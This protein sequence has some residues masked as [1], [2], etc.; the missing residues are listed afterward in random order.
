[1]TVAASEPTTIRKRQVFAWSLWDWGAAAYNAVIVSFVFSPYVVRGV[2]GDEKPGGLSGNTWLGISSATAGLLIALIA[3]VTGQ[4]SDASGHRKRNLAIWTGLTVAVMLGLF[5][6]RNEPAYLWIALVLLAAGA[7][8]NEFAGVSYNAM[9][10][11][12]STPATIGR[13]SGF[14]WSMGYFGGIF[15]LLTCYVGFI[16]PEVGW[17]GATADGGLKYRMVAVFSAAWFAL[18][19]LPV[20]I[21]VPEK[22]PGPKQRRVGFF[23]SYKVLARDIRELWR[24]ERNALTF[25]IASA[26]YRDGLTG[27]FTFGAILAVTV[28]GMA[29]DTVLIFGVVANVVAAVGAIT[30]GRIEDFVGPKRIIMISLVG[31][32][33]TAL[34]LLFA[35]GVTMFWIFGLILCLWVG[36]AQASSRSF[37]ARMA[38][39]G[40]EGQMF[41]LYAMTGRAAS[42][43]APG[44]FA[45]FSGLFSDRAGIIGIA[46]VLIAGGVVLWFVKP[47]PAHQPKLA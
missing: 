10:Q 26:L 32:V 13:I 9:L 8:F 31:L 15:L 44:L 2:V 28:Y 40:R 19:A 18:F 46:L 24:V 43:L 45:L 21:A 11:Q 27:V 4:R 30:L 16:A 34:I 29:Q 25:L 38:P 17:F 33:T 42:F 22:P 47:P 41:G 20:L 5:S 3:P 23:A 6:V 39:V 35:H 14:G 7:V 37:L 12:V 1:M 36:P